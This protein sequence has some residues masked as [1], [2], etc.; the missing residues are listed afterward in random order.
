MAKVTTVFPYLKSTYYHIDYYY[1]G[2]CRKLTLL[3]RGEEGY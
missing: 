1:E 3:L 2:V